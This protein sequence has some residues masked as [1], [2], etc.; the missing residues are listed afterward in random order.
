MISETMPEARSHE[1][2][3]AADFVLVSGGAGFVGSHLCDRLLAA[4]HRVLVLDDL[5]SGHVSHLAHLRNHPRFTLLRHD[6]TRP[7]P[8]EVPGQVTRI[9]NL[10]S[11][12]S[13][14]QYLP[15]GS[16]VWGKVYVVTAEGHEK[17]SNAEKL[18]P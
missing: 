6:I 17:G 16:T 4:G 9:F 15:Q 13:P 12:A 10:A 18:T 2:P 11:P 14:A 3:S 7:L 8:P 1:P 5:S